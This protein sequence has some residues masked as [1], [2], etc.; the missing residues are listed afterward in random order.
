MDVEIARK[1]LTELLAD[2][3]R[4]R[5]TLMGEH[6]GDSEELS[7]FDQHPADTATELSDQERET[8]VLDAVNERRQEVQ[9]A[10]DRIEAGTYGR[11]VDCGAELPDERLD[12]RPEAARCVRDQ[13][14]VE[15]ER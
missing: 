7:H 4:D 13:A 11:C 8:A 5:A 9:A 14:R 6:A 1:R 12:A 2:L 10:L 3:D 15:G